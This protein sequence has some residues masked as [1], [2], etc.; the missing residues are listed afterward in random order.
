MILWDMGNVTLPHKGERFI[1][2]LAAISPLT[3]AEINDIV[4]GGGLHRDFETGVIKTQFRF[5]AETMKRVGAPDALSYREFADLYLSIFDM[6]HEIGQV[7]AWLRPEIKNVIISN[8]DPLMRRLILEHPVIRRYI[9]HPHDHFFSFKFGTR[10]PDP[11]FF[12]APSRRHG[13]SLSRTILVDDN[14]INI[15]TFED[16]GGIGIRWNAWTDSIR[17]LEFA[18]E[19]HGVLC[20]Y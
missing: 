8:T 1:A 2:G 3:F 9:P 7:F 6:N 17:D 20:A 4:Y 15:A 5:F 10:K 12:L 13:I 11:E 19:S 16:I 14:E 18:L